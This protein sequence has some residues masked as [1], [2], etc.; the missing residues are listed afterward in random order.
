MTTGA[1]FRFLRRKPKSRSRRNTERALLALVGL[2]GVISFYPELLLWPYSA[3]RGHT[4]IYSDRPIPPEIDRVLARSDA[5]LGKSPIHEP[6]A[7]RLFLSDGGWRWRL[8]ALRTSGAFAFRRPLSNALVFNKNDIA[9]DL[10]DTG[11]AV[12]GKRSLSGVIAHES[13][14]I[15]LS[16]RYGHVQ[17]ATLPT[18]KQEG[19]ADHVAQ[20][21]SLSPDE[22]RLI[23]DGGNGHPAVDYYIARL[24]V[25]ETLRRLDGNVD[26]LM[27]LEP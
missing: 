6:F 15:L 23:R 2:F 27:L 8:L 20:E 16:R 18:W 21:S 13:V 26:A 1:R 22:Y 19:Y 24:R 14:H 9:A 25:E 10:I 4:K 12:A 17:A 3:E 7:R 11:R 5:L